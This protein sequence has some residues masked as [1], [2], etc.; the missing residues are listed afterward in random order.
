MNELSTLGHGLMIAAFQREYWDRESG[1]RSKVLG[2]RLEEKTDD[3]G[4]TSIY[5][6]LRLERPDGVIET[7]ESHLSV[8][9]YCIGCTK[10]DCDGSCDEMFMHRAEQRAARFHREVR[11]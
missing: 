5:P 4:E 8:I 1:M 11:R 3:E 9:T 2:F 6:I 10:D 7:E